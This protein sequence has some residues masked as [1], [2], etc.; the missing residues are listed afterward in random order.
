M[1][2]LAR[3]IQKHSVNLFHLIPKPCAIYLACYLSLTVMKQLTFFLILASVAT[4]LLAGY[5]FIEGW[6]FTRDSI[7][8]EGKIIAFVS[9]PSQNNINR[10]EILHYPVIN[11]KTKT[12]DAVTVNGQVGF[13]LHKYKIGDMVPVLY[14]PHDPRHAIV[15]NQFAIWLR[16]AL[17]VIAAIFFMVLACVT[18]LTKTK[19]N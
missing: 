8:T 5:F 6:R 13:Y 7:Q 9:K 14:H 18:S 12:G 2:E 4:F 3:N 17:V 11:F 1:V 19:K 10:A 15:G 16:F